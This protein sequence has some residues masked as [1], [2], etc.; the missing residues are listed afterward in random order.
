VRVFLVSL[1]IFWAAFAFEHV[2]TTYLEHI[3]YR[4]PWLA[5]FSGMRVDII[6]RVVGI[7][8]YTEWAWYLIPD[9]L[10]GA[11]GTLYRVYTLK[12][13]HKRTSQ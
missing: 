3:R 12:K 7:L 2:N 6:G 1:A 10:G 8:I 11:C 5:A 9:I 4:R 13:K